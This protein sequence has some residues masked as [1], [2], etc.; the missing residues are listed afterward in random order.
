MI[1]N[2]LIQL[3]IF[4][5]LFNF[6]SYVHAASSSSAFAGSIKHKSPK[7]DKTIT[8]RKN[9]GGSYV[10]SDGND[11]GSEFIEEN[12]AYFLALFT[13]VDSY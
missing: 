2:I 10:D 9:K 12:I 6:T 8:N 1:F 3:L 13:H 4:F 11:D 7:Y 5:I